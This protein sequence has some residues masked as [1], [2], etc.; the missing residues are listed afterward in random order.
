MFPS[1]PEDP[2]LY[3]PQWDSPFDHD[4]HKILTESGML[5]YVENA[6]HEAV[7]SFREGR[8]WSE[9]PETAKEFRRLMQKE[10]DEDRQIKIFNATQ[11]HRANVETFDATTSSQILKRTNRERR[12]MIIQNYGVGILYITYGSLVSGTYNVTAEIAASGNWE[13]P[14]P[15][16]TG[17]ISGVW[18]G[19]GSPGCSITELVD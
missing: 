2:T 8:H 14:Y 12:G 19:T 4:Q 9:L 13:M 11:C 6:I 17:N 7:V 1:E 10:M 16:Y 15:I 5:D 18:A 3:P